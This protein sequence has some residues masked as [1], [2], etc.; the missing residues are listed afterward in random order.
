MAGCRSFTSLGRPTSPSG[1]RAGRALQ[2]ATTFAP[3]DR[4]AHTLQ[5]AHGLL[6]M[7]T[8]LQ[9]CSLT[10]GDIT[11]KGHRKRSIL[12]SGTRLSRMDTISAGTGLSSAHWRVAIGT[13]VTFGGALR[14]SGALGFSSPE[15]RVRDFQ[16]CALPHSFFFSCKN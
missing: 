3:G 2:V 7:Y 5:V 14:S 6:G 1:G 9:D 11:Y 15:A 12:R 16:F 4:T 10:I 8:P 13:D